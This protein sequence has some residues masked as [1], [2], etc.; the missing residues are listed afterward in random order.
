[1]TQITKQR[2]INSFDAFSHK[3]T[4]FSK[5]LGRKELIIS[6]Y[7]PTFAISSQKL[8]QRLFHDEKSFW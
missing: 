2:D 1:M 8:P 4:L 7:H 6:R 3:K 5:L